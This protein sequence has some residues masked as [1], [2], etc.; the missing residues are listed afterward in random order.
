MADSIDII[1]KLTE[2]LVQLQP[3]EKKV[4]QA[5]LDHPIF[6][7]SASIT[8]IAQKAKV[9]E[10]TVTR[11]AK[12]LRCKNVRDLKLQIVRATAVGERF[13][14]EPKVAPSSI[15]GVYESIR[16][17]LRLNTNLIKQAALDACVELLVGARQVITMGV[18]GSST[19]MA[20][21]SQYRLFRLGFPATAYS[22][23]MLM[24][25]VAS[26]INK[27]DVII[28]FSL[29]GYSPDVKESIEIA[30]QYGAS[31]ISVTAQESELAKV[32]N[33]NLP[34]IVRESDYIYKPS[35]SRYVA[36]AT[37]DVLM[38]ELAAKN[39][40]RSMEKLR[41]LKQTLDQYRQGNDALPLGD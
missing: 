24:R 14:T 40:R 11:L 22:D 41:R 31:I 25:M 13:I 4:A 35:A 21:E 10:A 1:A 32:S 17:A 15:N 39:K 38:T 12:T 26:T 2:S 16:K 36:L 7:S 9:S 20:I 19:F 33:V 37:I 5:I 18:G 34:I 29:G 28:C 8:E 6:A 27:N 3:A 23:P 30:I